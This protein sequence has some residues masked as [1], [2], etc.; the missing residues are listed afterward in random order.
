MKKWWIKKIKKQ[1]LQKGHIICVKIK[2]I[3]NLTCKKNPKVI[4][5]RRKECRLTLTKVL[6]KNVLL[7]RFLDKTHVRLWLCNTTMWRAK[8]SKNGSFDVY[9][10]IV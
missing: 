3:A 6:K 7:L 4:M 1:L 8:V 9:L 5:I 2:M 10:G